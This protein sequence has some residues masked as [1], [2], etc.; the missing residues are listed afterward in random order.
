MNIN[1]FKKICLFRGFEDNKKYNVFY[2]TPTCY[3]QAVMGTKPNLSI[4]TGDFFPYAENDHAYW[5]GYYTSRPTI[6]R[7][8]RIGNNILQVDPILYQDYSFSRC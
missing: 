7:F 6:K 5:S 4:Y 3:Y 2:S 1:C 8:E